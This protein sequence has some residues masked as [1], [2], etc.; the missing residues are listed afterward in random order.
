MKF[1]TNLSARLFA[2]A[3]ATMLLMAMAWVPSLMAQ[4]SGTGGLA[5]TVTDPSNAV[6]PN[7][8][9]T[10]TD[11]AT[12]Q[13]R[14]ATTGNDGSY[15]F[16][17][18]PP[19]NY[20]V[21]FSAKGF[22]KAQ[23]PL[24]TINVTEVPV[25][26]CTLKIGA[27]SESVYVEA[28]AETIQTA[29]S[30]LGSL[31]GEQ[32]MGSLPLTNRNFT[33]ILDLSAGTSTGVNNAADLGRGTND[34]SV[35]GN[36]TGSNNFQMD[37]AGMNNY[38]HTDTNNDG[39]YA[40][41]VSIPNPDAI[42]EFM[43]QTSTYDAS[44]GRNPGANV[45]VVTKSGTNQF[46]GTAF[47]F[48]RN[49]ALN[50]AE[51][52]SQSKLLD[53]NQFGGVIGGP[54]KKNKLFFFASYQGT[55]QKNG[56]N[57][58]G[59]IDDDL[60]GLTSDR[61]AAGVATAVDPASGVEYC[62]E[63]PGISCNG[64]GIDGVALKLLQL[65]G[66]PTGSYLL[67]SGSGPTS[68]VSP[69]RYT[70]D[71]LIGN[72]D[73]VISPKNS[74]Q[75]RVFWSR[76]PQYNTFSNLMG[77]NG[78]LG[79]PVV[80]KYTNVNSLVRLTSILSSTFTNEVR[81]SYQ[82]LDG[83]ASDTPV[84]GSTPADLGMTPAVPGIQLPPMIW[85]GL[86]GTT[87]TLFAGFSPV[88]SPVNQYQIADQIA[89]S[90]GKHTIRAGFE[91]EKIQHNF[92]FAGMERGALDFFGMSD[93]LQG[94]PEICLFCVLG[95]PAGVRHDY[96]VND[97]ST[98]VQDDWKVSQRLTFNL[99]VRWEYFG[100]EYD[101]YGNLTN[102]DPSLAAA[103]ATP[104]QNMLSGPGLVGYVVP[105]NYSAAAWGPFPT[106]VQQSNSDYSFGN[107]PKNNWGPRFGFAW[108]PTN[109]AKLVVR[110]GFGLFYDR[111]SEDETVH[112]N[113]QGPPYSA[114]V[115]YGPGSGHTLEAPFS[116]G[117]TLGQYPARW[118]NL[119][120]APDG[121][122]C[123]GGYSALSIPYINQKLHTPLVR[124]Y[125]LNVQY[126]LAHNLVLQVA[127]VGGSG[128]NL[129]DQY[130]DTNVAQLASSSSP[131][132]GQTANTVANIPLRVPL[133]GFASGALQAATFDGVSLYNSLQIT[134]TKQMSRGLQM[135]AAYTWSK[136]LTDLQVPAVGSPFEFA[137]DMNNPSNLH[138]S[139]GPSSQNIPQRLAVNYM[140]NLPFG[141]HTGALGALANSWNLSGV[142]VAQEGF[143]ITVLDSSGGSI[144]GLSTATAELC[145]GVSAHQMLSSGSMFQRVT[146]GYFNAAAFCNEP[147]IGNGTGFGNSP[148]NG[149]LGPSQFNWDMSLDKGIKI[150]ETKS[151]E[152][153]T[154]FYNAFNHTQF[155][156]PDGSA[157]P[158]LTRLPNGSLGPV[159]G[160]LNA[161][162]VNPRL[163]QF[164]LKFKF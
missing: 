52:F 124:Q 80:F 62:Q 83:V 1:K 47:E 122:G 86:D 66:G 24:V 152:F 98:F 111:V 39:F 159:Q 63:V 108:Q 54:I 146:K 93:F 70:E 130:H 133:L 95:A 125:N 28:G 58:T 92:V 33:Q 65:M 115:S 110:G 2:V 5:G 76:N 134:M 164:G 10:A 144:Y 29:T 27:Q 84:A 41:G 6:I 158:S 162:S 77:G 157:I 59:H 67:P 139:Y 9:I 32:T 102:Y 72:V 156:D 37:G 140:Y 155:A 4:S 31:I 26:N 17:L 85:I 96:R 163:I 11:I 36:D 15:R 116:A 43:V 120:C 13:A 147:A 53:Q 18:L 51:Y 14:T 82:L 135:G 3:L 73:Y 137:A 68:Y 143:P 12:G 75:G 118:L 71:Q 45:N 78:G 40:A 113:E 138:N 117:F 57:S 22:K 61:S 46:H 48:F 132:N 20:K 8:G 101:K 49:A 142:T 161:T 141:Q 19:G 149:I 136:S 148:V 94:T 109:S 60:P 50:S 16:S 106:G 154:E 81:A 129:V 150:T 100:L 42:Q 107:P 64:A 23:F 56:L 30:S 25:L 89:W 21:E 7:V 123:T 112:G 104:T 114:T 103:V 145:P 126:E 69:A 153:R 99:G 151:F 34:I 119:T 79:D 74:F 160:T 121:T 44:Y 38:I 87:A 35:N 55:R 105:A 97:D 131:I 127:Y 90:H 91:T 88:T 128:I